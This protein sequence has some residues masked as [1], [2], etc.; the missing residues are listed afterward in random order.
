M[1]DLP[2][3]T[4]SKR[5][6]PAFSG[7]EAEYPAWCLERDAYLA[8]TS[9]TQI[10]QLMGLSDNDYLLRAN[11]NPQTFVQQA[12]GHL[13]CGICYMHTNGNLYHADADVTA[14]GKE[15]QRLAAIDM[16]CGTAM[17]HS[18]KG[19]TAVWMASVKSDGGKG[20]KLMTRMD[21]EFAQ[22]AAYAWDKYQKKLMSVKLVSGLPRVQTLRRWQ[23][24]IMEVYQEMEELAANNVNLQPLLQT[25]SLLVSLIKENAPKRQ[26]EASH[27]RTTKASASLSA[28]FSAMIQYDQDDDND[29]DEGDEESF[30]VPAGV[31]ASIKSQ[32]GA[33]TAAVMAVVMAAM[34]KGDVP[35][36][37]A[38]D[39]VPGRN[40]MSRD[41]TR[42]LRCWTKGCG[43]KD[44]QR[45]DCKHKN[46]AEWRNK[47]DRDTQGGGQNQQ[48]SGQNQHAQDGRNVRQRTPTSKTPCRFNPSGRCHAGDRCK[49]SHAPQ[50]TGM[51]AAATMQYGYQQHN[52]GQ[53]YD[54]RPPSGPPPIPQ[55]QWQPQREEW[56]SPQREH[57]EQQPPSDF[58]TTDNVYTAQGSGSNTSRPKG[59]RWSNGEW[60]YTYGLVTASMLCFASMAGAATPVRAE[61]LNNMVDISAASKFVLVDHNTGDRIPAGYWDVGE[62]RGAWDDKCVVN[63]VTWG[64]PRGLYVGQTRN[65]GDPSGCNHVNTNQTETSAR[66]STW[67]WDSGANVNVTNSREHFKNFRGTKSI[68]GVQDASGKAHQVQGFGECWVEVQ[69][70]QG[71]PRVFRIEKVLYVP[72]FALS[73]I[74]ESWARSA[75][76]GYKSVPNR[77]GRARVRAYTNDN[78]IHEEFKLHERQ[79]LNYVVGKQVS[80]LTSPV[81]NRAETVVNATMRQVHKRNHCNL[82]TAPTFR[83]FQRRVETTDDTEVL[84]DM[85]D[86]LDDE[87]FEESIPKLN[88]PMRLQVRLQLAKLLVLT[89]DD[90]AHSPF[91]KLHHTLGH[92]G[93]LATARI[94]KQ[95]GLKMPKVEER[96]CEYCIRAGLQRRAR[97]KVIVDRSHLRP[98]EKVFTDIEG[99]FPV[100][101]LWNGYKYLIGFID[102]KSHE[103][104]IYGMHKLD[105]VEEKTVQ[106]L[107]YVR[108]QK[109]KY[110]IGLE[111]VR[112][113]TLD[114]VSYTTLQGDS[115]SV[116]KSAAFRRT[117]HRLFQVTL[118][119]SPPHDQSRNGMI[120]RLWKTLGCRARAIMFAQRLEAG[121]W[122]W[123]YQHAARCHQVV[124]TS[125]NEKGLSPYEVTTGKSPIDEIKKLKP[126]GADCFVWEPNPG[127]LG[128]HGRKGKLIGWDESSISHIIYF[129][130]E[131]Y[132][133]HSI[134]RSRHVAIKDVKL[135]EA[136]LNGEVG[137]VF[138][139][140]EPFSPEDTVEV[141]LVTDVEPGHAQQDAETQGQVSKP[142]EGKD[143]G[144][145]THAPPVGKDGGV[146]RHAGPNPVRT[147]YEKSAEPVAAQNDTA[148]EEDQFSDEESMF[149]TDQEP[150]VPERAPP[151]NDTEQLMPPKRQ[152]RQ[153]PKRKVM[154][155][156]DSLVV[157]KVK[158]KTAR[159]ELKKKSANSR[160]LKT[161]MTEPME[162]EL[163]ISAAIQKHLVFNAC[164][165]DATEET[166]FPIGKVHFDVRKALKSEYSNCFKK[167]IASELE[168]IASHDVMKDVMMCDIPHGTKIFNSYMLCHR[169]SLGGDEWK[170]KSR[171]IADG[172]STIPGV[173]TLATDIST[174]LPRWAPL[175]LMISI[176]KG[177]GWSIRA[178]DVKTAFLK[179]KRSGITI[180][181]HMPVGMRQYQRLADGTSQEICKAVYGNLYVST[182]CA[183]NTCEKI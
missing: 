86:G 148:G 72:T 29:E 122:Y 153:L 131:K 170:C 82:A 115:H 106:Y 147:M 10:K 39:K 135:P 93:M 91:F 109:I 76:F 65:V 37:E 67:L 155:N 31:M 126:F 68:K 46:A 139:E 141:D 167:S 62:P 79:G 181:M 27:W 123:A 51:Q 100:R 75:G 99:P 20:S 24:D 92:A 171:L 84:T 143:G 5:M 166:E 164:L 178:G 8:E 97:S 138:P 133:Q 16:R 42:V 17:K 174:D 15:K 48:W 44:H 140:F 104:K 22:A 55:E 90:P 162:D 33:K 128:E 134:R 59:A 38:I 136:V 116:Y 6:I 129:P 11:P 145:Q 161:L 101:S 56:Q 165:V 114:P 87:G 168:S 176:A 23:N 45:G 14:A 95:M 124:G 132:K 110:E 43:S 21:A 96:F 173:H 40:G 78:V 169:K 107:N 58:T 154:F 157:D 179:G 150:E 57:R 142:P 7:K 74:S 125:A 151:V 149:M 26:R 66:A 183:C 64:Q 103:C 98:Y 112:H 1:A 61:Q 80:E 77:M 159:R 81:L 144:V 53:R 41:G 89:T 12:A 156:D 113:G 118:Q 158:S 120:E 105:E 30:P 180:F 73:I 175:R 4:T 160:N 146:Q 102:A 69:C 108:G 3:T 50:Q 54:T 111:T 63:T 71:S 130:K 83:E 49:F 13:Q 94:A 36:V 85:L 35:E 119:Y 60:L 117:M 70:S 28:F 19:G 88:A 32:L 182:T 163:L 34:G 25:E 127:K 172:S 9:A 177:K 47:R 2:T 18:L 152:L 52:G 121:Y 137:L